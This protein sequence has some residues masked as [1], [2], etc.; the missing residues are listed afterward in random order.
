MTERE[1]I[2]D[3]CEAHGIRSCVA[4]GCL[5]DKPEPIAYLH[6][7]GQYAHHSPALII[8]NSLALKRLRDAID[9][10]LADGIGSVDAFCED[11]EGYRTIVKVSECVPHDYGDATYLVFE[12]PVSYIP[13][14]CA[15]ESMGKVWEYPDVLAEL[16]RPPEGYGH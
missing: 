15:D 14:W 7:Y 16:R 3:A 4:K 2:D 10:A 9:T 13:D 11:G 1:R 5:P 12:H 6:I 8:G